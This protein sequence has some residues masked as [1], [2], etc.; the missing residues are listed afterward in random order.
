[1]T[2]DRIA[3]RELLE[4]GSGTDLLREMRAASSGRNS[5]RGD[6]LMATPHPFPSWL[7]PGR[8]LLH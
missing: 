7:A 8:I 3:L 1:M 6:S 5:S 2:I 4:K